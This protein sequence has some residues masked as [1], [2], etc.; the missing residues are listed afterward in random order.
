MTRLGWRSWLALAALIL[1]MV[2]GA[3]VTALFVLSGNGNPGW[4]AEAGNPLVHSAVVA[5]IILAGIALPAVLLA[6]LR[7]SPLPADLPAG[8]A[9]ARSRGGIIIFSLWMAVMFAIALALS[10]M[11]AA[12]ATTVASEMAPTTAGLWQLA[13]GAVLLFV[14]SVFLGLTWYILG[15]AWVRRRW[16]FAVLGKDQLWING[17]AA[18]WTGVTGIEVRCIKGIGVLV[19]QTTSNPVGGMLYQLAGGS[20]ALYAAINARIQRERS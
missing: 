20:A 12:L 19:C 16:P 15:K 17:R 11:V 6:R 3:G 2:V 18:P 7:P 10:P 13:V 5:G 4:Q 9:Y 1:W 8:E 14:C